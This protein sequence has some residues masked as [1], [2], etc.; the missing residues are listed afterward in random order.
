MA[1]RLLT[2]PFSEPLNGASTARVDIDSGSG[3][4]TIDR[5]TTGEWMLAS[6]TLQYTEKQGP[7]SRSGGS[8]GGQATLTLKGGGKTGRPWLRLPWEVCNGSN[9]WQVHLNPSVPSDITAHSGGGNIKVD[10]AGMAI[11]R[12]WAD[13]GGGNV[14]VT[15]PDCSAHLSVTV[16]T[17]AGN[18]VVRVPQGIAVRIHATSGLGKVIMDPRFGQVDRDAYQSPGYDG[19]AGRV[20]LTV[21]SGAGNVSVSTY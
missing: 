2:E 13:T 5:L 20:E 1:S 3:N 4:L 15:L 7:P 12:L 14:D 11:T 18:V 9:E 19:A 8:N 10:L 21:H 16:K 17:G 6:G